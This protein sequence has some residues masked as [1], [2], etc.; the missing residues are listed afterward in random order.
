[1]WPIL[2]IGLAIVAAL[3]LLVV[4]VIAV[5]QVFKQLK[6]NSPEGKLAAAE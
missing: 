4:G 3:A 6:K 1:M 5:I 2:L